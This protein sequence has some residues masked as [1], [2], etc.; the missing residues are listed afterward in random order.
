[1]NT[2]R[3]SHI[4]VLVHDADAATRLWTE[5][6][7][8]K[9]FLATKPELRYPRTATIRSPKKIHLLLAEISTSRARRN[10]GAP[11]WHDSPDLGTLACSLCRCW[12]PAALT[13][14]LA[15]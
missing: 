7:G 1:M 11:P 14:T 9:K 2:K 6:F 13:A 5:S 4:G 3:I 15:S 8:F 12:Q 10:S